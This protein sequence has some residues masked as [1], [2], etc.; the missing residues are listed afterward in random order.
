MKKRLLNGVCV[1][2]QLSNALFLSKRLA[3]FDFLDVLWDP[4]TKIN[5]FCRRSRSRRTLVGAV[6]LPIPLWVT[7]DFPSPDATW[8][9]T[10]PDTDTQTGQRLWA[11]SAVTTYGRRQRP[12]EPRKPSFLRRPGVR[13]TRITLS[14]AFEGFASW[15]SVWGGNN[16]NEGGHVDVKPQAQCRPSKAL[17]GG[18]G[19]K[20]PFSNLIISE[21]DD[22][23]VI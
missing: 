14:S 3:T 9:G 1:V 21:Y 22:P 13:G 23:S 7:P 8:E 18:L 16:Q 5:P 19:A 20:R 11:H 17:S 6:P 2:K 15:T 4:N 12:W 10:T